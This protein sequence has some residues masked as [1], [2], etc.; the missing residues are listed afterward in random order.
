MLFSAKN[1]SDLAAKNYSRACQTS[2]QKGVSGAK[3]VAVVLPMPN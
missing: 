1:N 2:P 3:M